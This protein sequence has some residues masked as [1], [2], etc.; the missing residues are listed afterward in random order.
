MF[1]RDLLTL[2]FNAQSTIINLADALVYAANVPKEVVQQVFV[3]HGRK[4]EFQSQYGHLDLS[5]VGWRK[6]SI[7]GRDLAASSH[8]EGFDH[9]YKAVGNRASLVA[10]K[11]WHCI[12]RRLTVAAH[13]EEHRTWITPPVLIDGALVNRQSR[14]HLMEGHTRMGLLSGLIEVGIID[15]LMTHEVWVGRNSE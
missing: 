9:W 6:R 15:G 14:F 4:P 13:W 10:T 2:P 7:A 8:F 1:F 11:G 12:D 5:S 3:E